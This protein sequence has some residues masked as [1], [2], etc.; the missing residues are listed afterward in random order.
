[1]Q[2]SHNESMSVRQISFAFK[3]FFCNRTNVY[4]TKELLE[5][6]FSFAYRE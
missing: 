1:M 5:Y 4:P 3:K 2:F 6:A